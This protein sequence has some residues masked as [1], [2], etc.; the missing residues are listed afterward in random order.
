MGM[1]MATI[2]QH[3]RLRRTT[4]CIILCAHV[5]SLHDAGTIT[6][7]EGPTYHSR[8]PRMNRWYVGGKKRIEEKLNFDSYTVYW[9]YLS[10]RMHTPDPGEQSTR[11]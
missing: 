10:N 1:S 6:D 4:V 2:L 3:L 8:A 5:F 11:G 9:N 7:P